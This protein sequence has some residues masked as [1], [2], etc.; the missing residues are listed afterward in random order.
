MNGH[1][2]H[3]AHTPMEP[4]RATQS[5][6]TAIKHMNLLFPSMAILRYFTLFLPL[7]FF[8][9]FSASPSHAAGF[10]EM[11]MQE[12]KIGVWYPSN[13][14][15]T[16]Q[17]LGPFQIQ[18]AKNAPIKPGKFAIVLFSH[19]NSG[20]FRNHHLTAATLADA[21]FIVIAPHHQADYL[22][23]QPNKTTSVLDRRYVDLFQALHTVRNSPQFAPHLA[24]API[25]GVG[26]SL[27]GASVLLAAG[28]TFDQNKTDLLCQKNSHIDPEF[29]SPPPGFLQRMGQLFIS[30]PPLRPTPKRFKLPP[31]ITGHIVLIAPVTLG[32][33]KTGLAAQSMTVIGIDGDTIAKPAFQVWPLP[34]EFSAIVPLKIIRIA[35]HHFAFI[36]PFLKSITDQE[37]I[38]IAKDPPGF[39]RLKFIDTVN[40]FIVDALKK[41][42]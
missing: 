19:G 26:Y 40:L 12:I 2:L 11:A 20:Q 6:L 41:Q 7:I 28:A 29:C 17:R 10:K 13:E 27:G 18:V 25:H 37:D 30:H 22:I 32:F 1:R 39:N 42:L 33:E 21:G 24:P 8:I 23:D 9:L 15:T 5:A 34:Q 31:I 35:G 16:P 36:S 4:P 3:H 38:P 14:K